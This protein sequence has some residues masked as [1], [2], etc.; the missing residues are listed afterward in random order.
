MLEFALDSLFVI[1]KVFFE[2]ANLLSGE[3]TEY[4]QKEKD[5]YYSLFLNQANLNLLTYF[6][7][8]PED[9]KAAAAAFT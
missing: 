4:R 7:E 3:Y 8:L 9:S 5:Y 2:V 6:L 1:A